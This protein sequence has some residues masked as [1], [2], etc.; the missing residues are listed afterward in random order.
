MYTSSSDQPK[1]IAFQ[2]AGQP[3]TA[4]PTPEPGAQP[5]PGAVTTDQVRAIAEEVAEAKFRNAQGLIDKADSRITKKVQADLKDL[6]KTIAM[7]KKLGIEV[8]PA[9]V[10]AMQQELITR[11]YQ[12]PETQ[13]AQPQPFGTQPAQ[14]AYPEARGDDPN[15]LALQMM[16]AS[17]V[18][19]EDGDP[20]V[21]QIDMTNPYLFL[22]SVGQAIQAKKS[23]Q[24]ASP[25]PAQP[26]TPTNAGGAGSPQGLEQE[27]KAA[28]KK[29]AGNAVAVGRLKMDFRK[30]GLDVW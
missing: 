28:L 13:P 14:A 22:S 9:T 20:E 2:Q 19:I 29:V 16:Q 25:R 24:A 11:A 4:S 15:A 10:S 6:E 17:G 8:P 18:M 1:P 27:Y 26:V 12:E 5:Q 30:R 7:Q 21:A 23:R 3:V